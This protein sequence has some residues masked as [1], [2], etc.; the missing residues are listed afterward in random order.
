MES[1][2]F[3]WAPIGFACT[4]ACPLDRHYAM[5]ETDLPPV[6]CYRQN[7]IGCGLFTV[8]KYFKL[9]IKPL[10]E[11]RE[12]KTE[13]YSTGNLK[14]T[15]VRLFSSVYRLQPTIFVLIIRATHYLS[16]TILIGKII[17]VFRVTILK[18][19]YLHYDTR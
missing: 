17:L 9:Y 18:T 13:K 14:R 12:Y 2:E 3:I 11:T 7:G 4:A 19:V 8:R 6:R 10:I 5:F 16:N 15:H 1:R